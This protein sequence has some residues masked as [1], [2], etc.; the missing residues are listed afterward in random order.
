MLFLA[1]LIPESSAAIPSSG[2]INRVMGA[3]PS[4]LVEAQAEQ[5]GPGGVA[6]A[7]KERPEKPNAHSS[8]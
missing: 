6:P 4:R 1:L 5:Q 2:W 3:S 8:L 7:L